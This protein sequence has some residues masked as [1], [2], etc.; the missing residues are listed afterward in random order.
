VCGRVVSTTT[1]DHL[2]DWL[3]IDEVV[4]PELAPS[5]N[6][7]PGRE[8][9]AVVRARSG[10]RRLGLMRWGLVPSWSR[11][12]AA[13]PRPINAR[14][15]TLLDRP[16]FAEA[17]V[18]RRCL[19]PVDGFYE[20]EHVGGRSR[21]PWFLAAADGSPMALAGLWDRWVAPDGHALVS[22][23]I[24]TV[25]A[26][27]DVAR[28]HDRMPAILGPDEWEAWLDPGAADPDARHVLDLLS[29]AD[30]GFLRLRPV[31]TRVNA[32]ANDGPD[33]LD[34]VEPQAVEEAATLF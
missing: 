4:A 24:V 32:V 1:V 30:D 16:A 23:A 13:G 10:S 20:W 21:Q 25:A 15:E 28:L 18:R 3:S 14:A 7:A 11:E 27:A 29:P 19:V 31:S 6:V 33:L 17:L 34:E 26:N 5:W 9:H 8:L 22:V 2:V 12:P